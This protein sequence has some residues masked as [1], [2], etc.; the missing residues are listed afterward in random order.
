MIGKFAQALDCG[1][2]FPKS[3]TNMDEDKKENFTIEIIK[4]GL[5]FAA[6]QCAVLKFT[7]H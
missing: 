1:N 2:I 4:K 6:V 7:Y 5:V 3:K